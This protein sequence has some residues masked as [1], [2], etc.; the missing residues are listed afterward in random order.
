MKAAANGA[1]NLSVLDGWWIEGF[2]ANP[3]TGWGIEPSELMDGKGD[4]ADGDAIYSLLEREVVPLFYERDE[5]DLPREWIR[6]SKEAIRSL[7]PRFSSQ[8]MVI[9][10]INRLY[11]PASAG[12]ARWMPQPMTAGRD[13][14]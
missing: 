13:R 10:Y 9:E 12:G 8:R 4:A 7:A 2:A 1:L 5:Q 3:D 6:R 14:R 11:V